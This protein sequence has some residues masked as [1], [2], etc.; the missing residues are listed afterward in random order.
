MD[1]RGDVLS[2]QQMLATISITWQVTVLSIPQQNTAIQCCTVSETIPREGVSS[3]LMEAHF[4]G[5][6][7]HEKLV[8]QLMSSK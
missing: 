1:L 5:L 6:H 2:F 4:Y 7:C 3:F 8:K